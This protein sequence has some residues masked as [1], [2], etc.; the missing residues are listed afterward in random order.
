MKEISEP[1]TGWTFYRFKQ[2]R[3]G[4]NELLRVC[5]YFILT[6]FN[7]HGLFGDDSQKRLAVGKETHRRCTQLG[8]SDI[9]A[10]ARLSLIHI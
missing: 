5:A 2:L 3:F 6:D 9:G 8:M 7:P 1:H 4:R 10:V